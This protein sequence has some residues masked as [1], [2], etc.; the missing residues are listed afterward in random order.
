MFEPPHRLA[1][2]WGEDE[3]HFE[4]APSDGGCILTLT[5]VLDERNAAAR[6][7]AGWEVCIGLLDKHLAGEPTDGAHSDSPEEWQQV[8]ESY[9]AGGLPAGAEVPDSA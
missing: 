7:A 2:T 9:V 4:L 5:N 6:N 1:Y 3:L 8:Y